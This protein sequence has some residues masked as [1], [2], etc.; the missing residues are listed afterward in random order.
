MVYDASMPLGGASLVCHSCGSCKNLLY[1]FATSTS[2]F[3][4]LDHA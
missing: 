4:M 2:Q 3:S 1:I